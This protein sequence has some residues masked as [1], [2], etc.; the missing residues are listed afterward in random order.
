MV[1]VFKFIVRFPLWWYTS[2]A[3]YT[4]RR[5]STSVRNYARSL[6]IG[7][8]VKNWFT[9]MFG[10]YDWQSRLISF[11]VRSAQIV[12]RG[13]VLMIWVGVCVVQLVAYLVLPIVAGIGLV[14]HLFGSIFAYG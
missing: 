10:Q 1:D 13:F 11:I 14:Y 7:V 2:G 6:A 3:L 4:A 8:W 12:G 9:P 5:L